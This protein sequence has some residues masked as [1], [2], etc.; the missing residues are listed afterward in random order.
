LVLFVLAGV[1]QAATYHNIEIGV[2]EMN[3]KR[4]MEDRISYVLRT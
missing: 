2:R 3:E 1:S 4:Q